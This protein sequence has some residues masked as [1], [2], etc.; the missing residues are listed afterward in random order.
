VQLP[1][2]LYEVLDATME[3]HGADFGDVQLYDNA[4][5]TRKI[6]AHRG[7]GQ[8]FLDHFDNVDAGDTSA[9]S[10]EEALRLI[11]SGVEVDLVLADFAMPEMTG[12]DLARAI[13]ATRLTLPI[14]L[15]TGHINRDFPTK[16]GES[17]ILQKPCTERELVDTITTALGIR[18]A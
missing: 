7:V 8:E 10:G 4:T 11:A 16:V 12:G 9:G 2:I 6:V 18:P 5:R 1:S 13:H 15:V 3:L 14:I 17:R